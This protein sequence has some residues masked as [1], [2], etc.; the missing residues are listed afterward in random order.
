LLPTVMEQALNEQITQELHSAYV[1]LAMSAYCESQN[2]PG[3]AH[4]LQLQAQ[5]ELAH[6]M[7]FYGFVHDR[8]G[9]VILQ[10]IPQPAADF[11]SVVA[12]FEEVLAHEQ[13]IS[14]GIYRLYSLA[15]QEKDYASIPFLQSFVTEQIEEEKSA[16][17]TLAMVRMAADSSP[18][19]LMLDRELL[20]R[21]AE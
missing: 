20:K 16:G 12:V 1:Y 21:Q 18:A 11:A 8:G 5:E 13:K 17:D 3:T 9:R 15:V 6:A 7:R 14:A 19:M 2:F 4:W 10:A